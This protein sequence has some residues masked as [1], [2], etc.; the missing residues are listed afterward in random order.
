V[1]CAIKKTGIL[2]LPQLAPIS[3]QRPRTHVVTNNN[4]VIG[5]H[6]P[7]APDLIPFDFAL[8]PKLKMKVKGRCFETVSDIQREL[9]AVLDSVKANDFHGAFEVWKKR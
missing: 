8:L 7:Y 9:L 6:P 4:L 2:A 3:R 5:P 1:K